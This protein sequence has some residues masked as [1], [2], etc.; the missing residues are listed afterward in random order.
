MT[1]SRPIVTSSS[2]D[3]NAA[4]EAFSPMVAEAAIAVSGWMPAGGSNSGDSSPTARAKA[5]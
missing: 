2:I 1:T 5:T 3:T 4:I